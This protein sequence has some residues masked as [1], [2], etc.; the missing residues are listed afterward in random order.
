ATVGNRAHAPVDAGADAVGDG[1]A[2]RRTG[3]EPR[4]GTA[5]PARAEQGRQGRRRTGDDR[6]ATGAVCR[7]HPRAAGPAAAPDPG[8]AAGDEHP[9]RRHAPPVAGWRRRRAAR[10]DPLRNEGLPGALRAPA[11]GAQPGVDPADR[12]PAGRSRRRAGGGG[13]RA[14]G[15]P[16]RRGGAAARTRARSRTPGR[17]LIPEAALA[18][19]PPRRSR[20]PWRAPVPRTAQSMHP[21]APRSNTVARAR[22]WAVRSIALHRPAVERRGA[23]RSLGCSL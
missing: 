9:A 16:R 10:T 22:P 5:L 12:S 13:C 3:P 1:N 11:G 19:R 15:R 6:T 17:T 4:R 14:P 21:T 18:T 8:A 20:T 23:R 7:R 2:A